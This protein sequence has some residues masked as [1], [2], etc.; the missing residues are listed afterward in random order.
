MCAVQLGVHEYLQ[1]VATNLMDSVTGIEK[2]NFVVMLQDLR[3]GTFH[4]STN[5]IPIPPKCMGSITPHTLSA[6]SGSTTSCSAADRASAVGSGASATRTAVSLITL[7]PPQCESVAKID[8]PAP[9]PS[10][11]H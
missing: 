1:G 10:S 8:N 7:D 3:R 9:D 5:W 11:P 4:Q 2:P 6:S